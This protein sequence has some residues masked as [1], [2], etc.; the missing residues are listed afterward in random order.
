MP[1]SGSQVVL[2]PRRMMPRADEPP[3]DDNPVIFR[4]TSSSTRSGTG[5]PGRLRPATDSVT[6][7]NREHVT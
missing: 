4:S 5:G 1:H 2:P 7:A 6:S 3:S